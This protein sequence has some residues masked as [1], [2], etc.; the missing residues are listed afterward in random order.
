M[1]QTSK[2]YNFQLVR[3]FLEV[4]NPSVLPMSNHSLKISAFLLNLFRLKTFIKF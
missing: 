4:F 1:L 3:K 2:I